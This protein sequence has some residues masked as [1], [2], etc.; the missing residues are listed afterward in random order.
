MKCDFCKRKSNKLDT[1]ILYTKS[2]DYCPYCKEEAEKIKKKLK[3]TI[4][5]Y[6][7]Y[8]TN[9]IKEVEK[10]LLESIKEED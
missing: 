6:D 3:W 7:R 4:D 2:L 5:Y 1:L 10:R 9:R 8:S